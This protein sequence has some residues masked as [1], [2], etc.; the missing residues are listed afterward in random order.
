VSKR[1]IGN[2]AV[3]GCKAIWRKK[4]VII[5]GFPQFCNGRWYIDIRDGNI[6]TTAFLE[7]IV[8]PEGLNEFIPV[9]NKQSSHISETG[10]IDTLQAMLSENDEAKEQSK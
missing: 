7:E 3:Y 4:L 2:S 9:L 1:N 5:T 8:M 10:Y 6:L